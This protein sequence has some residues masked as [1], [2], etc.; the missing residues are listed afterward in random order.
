[1][2]TFDFGLGCAGETEEY[3]FIEALRNECAQ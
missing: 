2:E 3:L 1:M